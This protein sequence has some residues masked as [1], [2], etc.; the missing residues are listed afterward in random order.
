MTNEPKTREEYRQQKE[1][2]EAAFKQRDQERLRTER[3]YAREQQ[4]E[5][6]KAVTEGE[7]ETATRRTKKVDPPAVKRMKKRLNWAIGITFGLIIIVYLI[8][9][10][11]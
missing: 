7:P 10:S 1:A 11:L 2:E 4:K 3:E 6:L 5:A 9:F 8:L